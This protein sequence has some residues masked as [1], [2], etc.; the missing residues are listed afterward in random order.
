MTRISLAYEAGIELL[1]GENAGDERTFVDSLRDVRA[2][3][4]KRVS[5]AYLDPGRLAVAIVR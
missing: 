3:A 4:V 1:R 2:D 5:A